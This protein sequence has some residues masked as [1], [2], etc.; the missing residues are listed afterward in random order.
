MDIRYS[1]APV[2]PVDTPAPIGLPR[3]RIDD[4]SPR[5]YGFR[6]SEPDRSGWEADRHDLERG[7][8]HAN[9][10]RQLE[11]IDAERELRKRRALSDTA[12]D[13]DPERHESALWEDWPQVCRVT[14]MSAKRR[15]RHQEIRYSRSRRH[16]VIVTI[17]ACRVCR[18]SDKPHACPEITGS[19]CSRRTY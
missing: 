6:Y 9:A 16:G 4:S 14:R 12:T 3:V 7:R 13:T 11:P 5:T 8:E 2:D 1:P 19:E 17:H 18:T 10:T 15:I